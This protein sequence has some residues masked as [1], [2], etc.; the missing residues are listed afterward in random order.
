MQK[1]AEE[2]IKMANT[3]IKL[4]R[5]RSGSIPQTPVST[6]KESLKTSPKIIETKVDKT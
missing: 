1:K 4:A 5:N 6:K 3:P 2:S